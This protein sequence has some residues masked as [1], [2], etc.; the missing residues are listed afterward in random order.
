MTVQP[1]GKP[2]DI[3]ARR[4]RKGD[5]QQRS[6]SGQVQACKSTLAE[7]G[8]PAGETHVDDGRSAWNPR[9]H[10]PGWDA[11]MAR[12]ESGAS[13]GVIVFDLERFSRQPIEGER[14]IQAADRGLVVLDS[15]AEF[16]LT[17]ASG[18][19]SFRDAMSAAAYYSD[20]LSDRVRR[21]KRLKA[22][23]GEPHGRVNADHG[24]FGFRPDGIT[25][26]PEEAVILREITRR[27]LAGETQDALIADLNERGVT[28]AIGGR[29]TRRSLHDVL[30]RPL[31]AGLVV[32]RGEIVAVLPGEPVI[33]RDD[34]ERVIAIYAAR[35]P[36]RPPSGAYLCSGSVV[37]GLCGKPLGGRPRSHLRPYPD[38]EVRREYWCT[39][40]GYGGCGHTSVDQRVLD[41]AAQKL[42]IEILADARHAAQVEAAVARARDEAARLDK[43][44]AEL[45]EL[46]LTL[47]DRLG[48][49]EI[50]LER[51]DAITAP[52]DKRLAVLRATRAAIGTAGS[53]PAVPAEV[54]R[55][56][57][58]DADPSERRELLRAALRGRKIVIG[59]AAPGD[60]GNVMARITIA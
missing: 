22:V 59:R 18:K 25:P 1:S 35:R 27:F 58:D 8:Q 2:V 54:W 37:C 12:L 11:L 15:D 9:V 46:V 10:R 43:D 5:K 56:R 50:T 24:P 52:L 33:T 60:R 32:H 20:R 49:G 48:R 36:G 16:D 45:E 21:G 40:T 31:N 34:H 7:R 30:I 17:T 28:T 38:G 4:S 26:H 39:R 42:A 44:I 3:Y 29:W 6:T 14:L 47:G 55:Q 53:I 13:G 19:K 51:Y 57:W 23:S 41:D